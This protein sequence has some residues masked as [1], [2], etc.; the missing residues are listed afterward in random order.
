[1]KTRQSTWLFLLG[2]VVFT[3]FS[4]SGAWAAK[5]CGD[6]TPTG[7]DTPC[8][9]GDTV[10]SDTVLDASDPVVSG[11][12]PTSV[13]LAIAGGVTLDAHSLNLRCATLTGTVGLSI[14]G[15]SVTITH[16]ISR[17]CGTAV[18][19]NTND[20]TIER[21]TARHGGLGIHFT[22]NRNTLLHNICEGSSVF[23]GIFFVGDL[24]TLEHNY[25]HD[26]PTGDAI[27]FGGNNNTLRNNLC[28]RSGN[29]INVIQGNHNVLDRNYCRDNDGNGIVV[30]GSFN[31]L[32]SNRGTNNGSHGVF[33]TGGNNLT[34]EHNFGSGN[35]LKPDCS[36]DGQSTTPD[37]R[38]C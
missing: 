8:D 3:A 23:G 31:E 6:N 12:C 26:N 13:G 24:N 22:G 21:V 11:V 4:A 18:F 7:S 14:L 27:A 15:E 16:G 28:H 10:T 9:C 19:G 38:Y 37:G 20:S 5:P 35:V 2:A 36:I 33:V 17:G 34:D 29:G 1:M 32:N 30:Q 25:C